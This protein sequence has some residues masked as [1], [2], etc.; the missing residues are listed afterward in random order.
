MAAIDK[1]HSAQMTAD[2]DQDADVLYLLVG[3]PRPAEGE[4]LPGG[5]VRRYALDDASPCGVTII[6]YHR[7]RWHRKP[8]ILAKILAEHLGADVERITSLVAAAA[9]G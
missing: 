3:E 4:D 5:I 7:S 2:Y 8:R 6:G 9:T 1:H